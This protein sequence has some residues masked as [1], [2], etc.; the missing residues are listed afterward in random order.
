[1]EGGCKYLN[2]VITY[3]QDW[4]MKI[5]IGQQFSLFQKTLKMIFVRFSVSPEHIND[6]I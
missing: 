6:A 5:S 2:I 1:M 4:L 3:T